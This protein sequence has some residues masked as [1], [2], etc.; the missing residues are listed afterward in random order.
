[1]LAADVFAYFADL[2]PVVAASAKVMEA[3]GLLAFTVETHA[4]DGIILGEKLRYAHGA[5]HVRQACEA[6]RLDVVQLKEASTRNE[7]DVPVPGLVA[8]AR[9]SA[10]G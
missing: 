10:P 3:G 4:G 9:H 6:A 8:V 7:A 5:A 2:A 1:M